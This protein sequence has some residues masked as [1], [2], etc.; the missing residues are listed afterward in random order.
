MD[1]YISSNNFLDPQNNKF[2]DSDSTINREDIVKIFNEKV[3]AEE[4]FVENERIFDE[5]KPS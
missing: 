2:I 3:K 4:Q 1:S 5:P